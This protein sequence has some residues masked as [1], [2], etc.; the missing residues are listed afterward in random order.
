MARIVLTSWGSHG[1]V[2]PY[3]GLALELKRRGHDPVF[4]TSAHYGPL[5]EEVGIPFHLSLIHI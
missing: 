4:A 5:I 1:D 2:F 3:L